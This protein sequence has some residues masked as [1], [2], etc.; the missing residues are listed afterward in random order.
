MSQ[1]RSCRFIHF[2]FELWRYPVPQRAATQGRSE[3]YLGQWLRD[4][5]ISRSRVFLST[6]V[7]YFFFLSFFFLI[8]FLLT[9][10]NCSYEKKNG[11]ERYHLILLV[12]CESLWPIGCWTFW[13]DDLDSWWSCFFGCSQH[14]GSH[15]WQVCFPFASLS[16][17]V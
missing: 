5:D 6:K 15:R 2:V 4:R 16:C 17:N 13:A 10:L 11:M 7:L 1:F 9:N 3:E 14:F 12:L 8:C